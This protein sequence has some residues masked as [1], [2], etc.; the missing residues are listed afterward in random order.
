MAY[1][2]VPKVWRTSTSNTL[3]MWWSETFLIKNVQTVHMQCIKKWKSIV[4][5]IINNKL[6][7][8][9]SI[10]IDFHEHV[11][12]PR[13]NFIVSLRPLNSRLAILEITVYCMLE[14]EQW[15]NTNQEFRQW[16]NRKQ[17]GPHRNSVDKSPIY[18][19]LFLQY[20]ST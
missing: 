10:S 4:W 5:T 14:L 19:M 9:M 13:T 3:K 20:V 15:T 17:R 12:W 1:I 18:C 11:R 6:S 16:T 2:H 8:S 7:M